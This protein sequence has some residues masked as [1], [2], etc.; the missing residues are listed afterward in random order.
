MIKKYKFWLTL[1]VVFQ[2]LT[3]LIH[4]LSFFN[5][6]QPV[7]EKEEQLLDLLYNY[8]IDMGAGFMRSMHDLFTSLSIAF[9]LLFLFGGIL[10]WYLLKNEDKVNVIKGIV[11]I[12]TFIFGGC[13]L[14]MIVFAFL[15]PIVL[16]GLVFVS[17]M[18]TLLTIPRSIQ[19]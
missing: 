17:L 1:T 8:K 9:M 3:G 14:A 7:N 4:T 10:N 12:N 16:N 13:L 11:L 19:S 18:G 6:H 2:L 5:K 15:P